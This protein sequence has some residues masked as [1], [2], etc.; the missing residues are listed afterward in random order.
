MR[1]RS[2]RVA[3]PVAVLLPRVCACCR[4]G[5]RPSGSVGDR[6]RRVELVLAAA[7]EGSD[8]RE[9]A[10]RGRGTKVH[11]L[12]Q[13]LECVWILAAEGATEGSPRPRAPLADGEKGRSH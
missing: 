8:E 13:K 1:G 9:Q 11:D 2:E 4:L 12:R 7:P 3:A 10:G 5:R 6:L